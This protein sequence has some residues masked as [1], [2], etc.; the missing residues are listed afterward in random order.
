MLAADSSS[1][2]FSISSCANGRADGS[3]VMLLEVIHFPC[4]VFLKGVWPL[5]WGGVGEGQ[6]NANASNRGSSGGHL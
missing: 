4:L 3:D 5:C 6:A 1:A 2:L